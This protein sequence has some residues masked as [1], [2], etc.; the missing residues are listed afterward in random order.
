ME[1]DSTKRR[2][3][4]VIGNWAYKASPL[5]NPKNDSSDIASALL[6]LDFEVIY[7]KN[8]N[9]KDMRRAIREFG[10]KLQDG[11]VGLFFYAG[12]G[13]QVEG[14]NYLIPIGSDIFSEDEV[15]D[16]AVEADLILRKMASARNGMNVVILDACRNNPY[17]RSFRSGRN[18]LARM[19]APTGTMIAY[20][21]S[22]GSVAKDGDGRNSPYTKHLLAQMRVPGQS[23][24]QTFKRV[25]TGVL[26]DTNSQQTP[27]ESSSL[28]G[29]FWFMPGPPDGR[30]TAIHAPPSSLVV[31]PNPKSQAKTLLLVC[32][33]ML[34]RNALTQPVTKKG[35]P[36]RN[37]LD[38]FNKVQQL[39][40]NNLAAG[41]GLFEI[42]KRYAKLASRAIE[43]NDVNKAKI[44]IERMRKIN[45][46]SLIALELSESLAQLAE[47]VSHKKIKPKEFITHKQEQNI[48]VHPVRDPFESWSDYNNRLNSFYRTLNKNAGKPGYEVAVATLDSKLYNSETMIFPV[49]LA[50]KPWA[51]NLLRELGYT[52]LQ[53]SGENARKLFK[54]G[55]KHR[56]Y[57]HLNRSNILKYVFLYDGKRK[58]L[59]KTKHI[60]RAGERWKDPGSG[61]NFVWVPKGCFYMGSKK[62]DQD[63][64]PLHKVCVDGFWIGKYEVSLR[65]WNKVLDSNIPK[66]KL[67]NFPVVRVSL[68][69]VN[70]FINKMNTSKSNRFR[71]PT[72]AE[73]EYACRS[74]GKNELFAGGANINA[75]A[76]YFNNSKGS[77]QPVGMKKANKL[78]IHD[79]SGN[80][81]EWVQDSYSKTAYSNHSLNNPVNNFGSNTHVIRGGSMK[82]D[83]NSARCASR[84]HQPAKSISDNVGFRIIREAK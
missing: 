62:G 21:T 74:A 69:K 68:G 64:Q 84:F 51:K 10:K 48:V 70:R 11:G 55:K 65:E 23:I 76:W 45:P 56:I 16:E 46:E 52:Y 44:Y 73:W 34:S 59:L 5:R 67:D 20:S 28:T 83:A 8:A 75:V 78:G 50:V 57:A 61:I 42:E 24:E 58:L 79:M 1:V 3:A 14:K 60:T 27:W 54:L 26:S 6:D 22:P 29:N 72:E 77:R 71:L 9:R 18:G 15:A 63:E 66:Q 32:Q 47:N 37:A 19:N 30:P 17:E 25:R 12:H 81:W 82:Y 53:I 40:Y 38:C 41:K 36:P 39:D 49:K 80:V 7:K 4:L 43:K 13:M 35:Q 33:D 31:P 2:I